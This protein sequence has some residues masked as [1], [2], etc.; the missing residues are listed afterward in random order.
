[1]GEPWTVEEVT[2][3]TDW[4]QCMATTPQIV[5]TPEALRLLGDHGRTR[6]VRNAVSL[7]LRQL[8]QPN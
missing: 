4:F 6:R 2:G 3:A 1:M 5:S 7:R 8:E